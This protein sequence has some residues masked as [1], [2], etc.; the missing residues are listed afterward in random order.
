MQAS[1]SAIRRNST[2]LETI[3]GRQGQRLFSIETPLPIRFSPAFRSPKLPADPASLSGQ[4]SRA[5][6][7][8]ISMPQSA[9]LRWVVDRKSVA[10]GTR[11]SVRVVLGG[12]RIIQ[13]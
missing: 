7:L 1:I 10:K 3:A 13:K 5:D 4:S 11:G 9:M 2:P 6:L 12:G 8:Q